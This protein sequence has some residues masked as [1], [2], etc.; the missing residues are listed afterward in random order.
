MVFLDSRSH[1]H[2]VGTEVSGPR[3]NY[4]ER[5]DG[6][7]PYYANRV[8]RNRLCHGDT[9]AELNIDTPGLLPP[10][11]SNQV[12]SAIWNLSDGVRGELAHFSHGT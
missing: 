2:R 3:S 8:W 12:R 9:P 7:R 11:L 4:R 1:L 5:G 6:P 10:D